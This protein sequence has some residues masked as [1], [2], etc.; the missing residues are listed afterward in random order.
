[1]YTHLLIKVTD[2]IYVQVKYYHLSHSSI[3][4]IS[5]L[6]IL[7]LHLFLFLYWYR[8]FLHVHLI[9]FSDLL[10]FHL[11]SDIELFLEGVMQSIW[12]S[13]H[14]H[15]LMS[16]CLCEMKSYPI[17]V[18]AFSNYFSLRGSW[19]DMS[20]NEIIAYVSKYTN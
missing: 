13:A 9:L 1:M 6:D 16:S 4:Q 8:I 18:Q 10:V 14:L 11:D 15:I 20:A 12:I 5:Y 19:L 7:I 3:S 17:P 2:K